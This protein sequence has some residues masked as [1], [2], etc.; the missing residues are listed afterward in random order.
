MDY[1]ERYTITAPLAHRIQAD[2]DA[3]QIADAVEATWLE[4]NAALT[5]I[6]GQRG[7]VAL[8]KRSLYLSAVAH[9]WLDGLHE[10]VP[11]TLDLARLKA[12]VSRQESAAAAA[13][14]CDLFRVF[15]GLLESMVGPSLAERLLRSV[16]ALTPHGPAAQDTTP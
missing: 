2:A 13:G 12:A 14:G 15:Y 11:S 9:P 16:W 1:P 6:V 10:G 5:P 4:I 3:S 7:M 8:Y